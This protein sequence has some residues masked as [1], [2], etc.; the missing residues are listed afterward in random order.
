MRGFTLIEFLIVIAIGGLLAGV[1]GPA[2][3]RFPSE[4]QLDDVASDLKQVIE[5][6]R[7][8]S[9][10][11]AGGVTHGV[12]LELNAGAGVSDRYVLFRG[13]SYATRDPLYDQPTIIKS[14]IDL[15]TTLTG[16]AMT[17]TFSSR[18][19]IPNVIGTITLAHSTGDQRVLNLNELGLVAFQ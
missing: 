14:P 4:S 15:T 17:I 7:E 5:L 9:V 16:G 11:G 2:F 6:A 13:S 1:V 18:W 3:S 19:G 8:R 10:A 12:F